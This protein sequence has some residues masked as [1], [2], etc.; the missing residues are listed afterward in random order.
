VTHELHEVHADHGRGGRGLWLL[1]LAAAL[2]AALSARGRAVDRAALAAVDAEDFARLSGHPASAD[3]EL[4]DRLRAMGVRAAVLREE[5]LADLASRGEVAYFPRADVDRWRAAGLLPLSSPLRGDTLWVKDDASFSRAAEALAA[6][7]LDVSTGTVGV[8]RLLSL[9]PNADLAALPAGFDPATVA[10]LSSSGLLP[11]AASTGPVVSI[12]G[13][14]LWTR[15][16]AIDASFGEIMRAALGRPLRLVVFR[17]RPDAGL[18]ANVERL[19]RSLRV[20]RDAA[21]GD[22]PAP[23]AAPVES[24]LRA[25]ARLAFVWFLGLAGPLLAVR[26]GLHASRFL[27]G[28]T[29]A[30][31]PLASPVPQALGGLAA[32][33]ASAALAGLAVAGVAPE[34][35][36]D[37]SAH[38]WTLWTWCAPLAVGGVA[39]FA[40]AAPSRRG[41]SAPVRRRDLAAL[42]VFALAAVLLA[43]PRAA[44]RA[45][46]LWESFDRLSAAAGALWWWPWRW[47]EALVGVPALA[48]AFALVEERDSAAAGGKPLL[49]AE[50]RAWLLLGLLAP[51]G[52]IAAVGGGGESVDAAL[53]HGVAANVLGAVLGGALAGLRD[54]MDLWAQSPGPDGPIDPGSLGALE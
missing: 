39:L 49:L 11:V 48:L 44:V 18:D 5:T 28:P 29:R 45:S 14:R 36:R 40:S 19:R 25:R 37:G 1:L 2:A 42:G 33:W 35:W 46:S 6:A 43:A 50:P 15:T 38:A 21:P 54:L 4:W 26:A 12:A 47:R 51:A 16:I 8:P 20:L 30:L 32:A 31:L 34:G 23:R 3:A 7:G 24:A 52:L 10:A 17:A 53:L 41:W 13:Q 27:R 22:L 9:P